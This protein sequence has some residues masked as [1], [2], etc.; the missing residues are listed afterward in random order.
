MFL[1]VSKLVRLSFILKI[2]IPRSTLE[3]PNPPTFVREPPVTERA[4]PEA[5][6]TTREGCGEPEDECKVTCTEEST[7]TVNLDNPGL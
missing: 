6:H 7:W 5:G 2:Q 3:T 1:V 4:C